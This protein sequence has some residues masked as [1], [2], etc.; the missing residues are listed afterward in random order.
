MQLF[1]YRDEITK[2][3][4]IPLEVMINEQ[5]ALDFFCENTGR[6]MPKNL[7]EFIKLENI[8]DLRNEIKIIIFCKDNIMGMNKDKSKWNYV[9]EVD[10]KNIGRQIV[11][12]YCNEEWIG[13]KFVGWTIHDMVMIKRIG[14]DIN[15]SCDEAVFDMINKPER[16]MCL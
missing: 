4:E 14:C 12:F 6:N 11:E 16:N 15:K 2:E 1:N 13:L 7:D 3:V 10:V 9:G 8:F 5:K